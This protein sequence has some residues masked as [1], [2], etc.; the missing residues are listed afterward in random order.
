M[1]VLFYCDNRSFSITIDQN[2][3]WFI[4]PE[5]GA[6]LLFPPNAVDKEV[7]LKFSRVKHKDCQVKPNGGEVFVS[8]ILK[9]EP[10]GVTFEKPVTVLLCHSLYEDQDFLSFY[11]LIVEN[12]SPTGCQEL[13][14]ER[15]SCIKGIDQ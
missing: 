9:I 8:Q 4:L 14:T 10:E 1:I 12:L 2:G 3:A 13:K 15:I 6:I 5:I 11:D 7:T